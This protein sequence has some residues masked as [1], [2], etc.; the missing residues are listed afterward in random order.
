M[1]A[2]VTPVFKQLAEDLLLLIK[3]YVF[4]QDSIIAEMQEQVTRAGSAKNSDEKNALRKDVETCNQ[5]YRLFKEMIFVERQ[6]SFT[7]WP[8]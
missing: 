7:R 1:E 6:L 3:A 4:S 8:L 5:Y 2:G